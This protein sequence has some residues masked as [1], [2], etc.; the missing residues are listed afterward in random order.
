MIET[1]NSGKTGT[2]IMT[3]RLLVALLVSA[4]A[5]GALTVTSGCNRSW[6]AYTRSPI[7]V[8]TIGYGPAPLDRFTLPP[9]AQEHAFGLAFAEI[10]HSLFPLAT[11]HRRMAYLKKGK[12]HGGEIAARSYRK[13]RAVWAGLVA[14]ASLEIVAEVEVPPEWF[15]EP[16]NDWQPAKE[17]DNASYIAAQIARETA[18]YSVS[19]E[20]R[21][22]V[23]SADAA[24]GFAL[25]T[26]KPTPWSQ[27]S[28]SEGPK[29][30]ARYILACWL[31]MEGMHDNANSEPYTR[32][33]LTLMESPENFRGL[34]A[35]GHVIQWRRDDVLNGTY[36]VQTL[37]NLGGRRI[38]I[39][40]KWAGLFF[41]TNFFGWGDVTIATFSGY[42]PG[43]TRVSE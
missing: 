27:E 39:R 9:E 2:G 25:R 28:E 7:G 30:A 43:G 40:V 35:D 11:E 10:S 3:A 42:A 21:S 34:T 20:D 38:E 29:C 37:R 15:H 17:W 8:S 31:V 19:T 14:C 23:R 6:R 33:L 4:T 12:G 18:P 13:T 36:S 24:M 16:P 22:N 1:C 5:G 26:L 32:A 41:P